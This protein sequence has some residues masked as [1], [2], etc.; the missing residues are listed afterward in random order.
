MVAKPEELREA[1]NL[2]VVTGAA[3]WKP[4]SEK[5]GG[6]SP[7]SPPYRIGVMV[8]MRKRRWI[9]GVAVASRLQMIAKG[10]NNSETELSYNLFFYGFIIT[11]LSRTYCSCNHDVQTQ[12]VLSLPKPQPGLPHRHR[13]R[14]ESP[15][16]HCSSNALPRLPRILTNPQ[17]ILPHPIPRRKCSQHTTKT[18]DIFHTRS[19]LNLR[20]TDEDNN[21]IYYVNSS[22]FTPG[23]PDVTFHSGSS[24]ADPVVAIARWGH[25]YDRKI[26]IGLGDPEDVGAVVRPG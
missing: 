19:H 6:I 15:P 5:G 4:L 17:L 3:P 23:T 8:C 7:E 1:C 18:Y 9:R 14:R 2:G 13:R 24:K 10:L 25:M 11:A 21:N 16:C 22:A 12:H 20:I 26:R